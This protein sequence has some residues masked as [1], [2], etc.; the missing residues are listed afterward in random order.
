MEEHSVLGIPSPE[1]GE[2]NDLVNKVT[3]APSAEAEIVSASDTVTAIVDA[4]EPTERDSDD[5]DTQV[6]PR[7]CLAHT[8]SC[9]APMP[10][11]ARDGVGVPDA[12]EPRA[13]LPVLAHPLEA[14]FNVHRPRHFGEHRHAGRV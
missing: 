13:T 10:V 6:R 7:A 2:W 12:A 8:F 11:R 5:T 9:F 3:A 4:E 1:K 14:L